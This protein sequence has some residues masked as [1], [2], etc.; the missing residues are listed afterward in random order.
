MTGN[1]RLAVDGLHHVE[2]V[3]EDELDA[4]TAIE[5]RQPVPGEDAL[6][7][8][9]QVV[10]EGLDGPEEGV[11]AAGSGPVSAVVGR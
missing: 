4:L 8:D 10:A 3:A 5:V 9:D 1:S 11:R 2:G 6:D 7:G